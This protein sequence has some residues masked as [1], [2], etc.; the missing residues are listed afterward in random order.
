M[1]RASR[2][3][4]RAQIVNALH[5]LLPELGYD[6]ASVA[7]IAREAGLT[8]G[9]VHYHFSTKEEILLALVERLTAGLEARLD[10]RLGALA[11]MPPSPK[12]AWA[13][14][15]AWIDAH[16]ALGADADPATVACWVAIGGEALRKAE[17]RAA[18]EQAVAADLARGASLVGE[19]LEATWGADATAPARTVATGLLAAIEGSYRLASAAPGVVDPGFAAPSVRA[20]ARG[21]LAGPGGPR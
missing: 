21:L 2:A 9:L 5:G 17:V 12:L 6:G 4:R 14:L 15:D 11:P 8:P 1:P 16:L 10:A 20:M 18:Y 19:V 7:R 13:R 3:E